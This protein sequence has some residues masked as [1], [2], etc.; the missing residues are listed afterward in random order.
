MI[1][2]SGEQI[3]ITVKEKFWAVFSHLSSFTGLFLFIVT[4]AYIAFDIIIQYNKSSSYDFRSIVFIIIP[5]VVNS[6]I[7][8]IIWSTTRNISH[9][10]NE[11]CK[12]SLNFQL[13]VTLYFIISIAAIFII[14]GVILLFVLTMFDIVSVSDAYKKAIAGEFYRYPFSIHFVR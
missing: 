7:P 6:L 9:F 14:F 1:N 10:V 2:E 11:H 13:S 3:K 12:Q 5:I 8:F 4:L